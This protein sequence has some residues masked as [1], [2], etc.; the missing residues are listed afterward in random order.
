MTT[1]VHKETGKKYKAVRPMDLGIHMGIPINK[2]TYIYIE[3]PSLFLQPH[4][5]NSLMILTL[6]ELNQNFTKLEE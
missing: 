5:E 6:E 1:Y 4:G 3:K 2:K